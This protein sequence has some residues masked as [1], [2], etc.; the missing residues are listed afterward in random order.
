MILEQHEDKE[1]DNQWDDV[2]HS[3]SEPAQAPLDEKPKKRRGRVPNKNEENKNRRLELNRQSA[4]E[5]RKR[6]KQYMVNLEN[7]NRVLQM[8]KAKLNRKINN[9]EEQLRL[10][11]LSH[12]DTTKQ[13]MEGSELLFESLQECLD[14]SEE[15]PSTQLDQTLSKLQLR[16]QQQNIERKNLVKNLF[17]NIIDLSLPSGTKWLFNQCNL[18]SSS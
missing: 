8:E 12:V 4:K 2:S 3:V 17:D 7:E 15:E 10:N 1:S 6:K 16:I 13:M 11:Y 9:L 14:Q 18:S 5:S